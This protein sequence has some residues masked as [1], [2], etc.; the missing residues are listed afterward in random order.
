[1]LVLAKGLTS[2]YVPLGAVVVD[3]EISAYFDRHTLWTGLTYSAHPVGCAAAIA[4]LEVY[5]SENLIARSAERGKILHAG[6]IDL[7]ERHPSVGDVR[8]IGLLHLFELVASR[9]TREPLSGFNQPLSDPM[10]AVAASLRAQGMSTFVRWNMIF[11][12][13]PLIIDESQLRD[14]IQILDQALAIADEYGTGD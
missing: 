14:G 9:K 7:A 5:R 11:C 6:L 4:N 13:P 10:K 12:T 3:G 8:G 1:M 2:G